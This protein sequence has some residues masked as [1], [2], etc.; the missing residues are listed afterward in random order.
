M[1][2]TTTVPSDWK[3]V[4]NSKEA[5]YDE[6]EKGKEVLEKNSLTWFTNFYSDLSKVAV[7]DFEQTPKIS[8]Y[9]YVICAGPYKVFEDVAEQPPQRVFVRESL[10]KNLRYE[11]IMGI[12]KTT[13]KV[14]E[15]AFG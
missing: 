2:L 5:R 6:I 13:I 14:Y 9:L 7:Y 3:S 10:I 4:S 8:T 15:E 12:A 11:L 1:K